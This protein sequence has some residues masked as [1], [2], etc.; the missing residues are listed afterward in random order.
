MARSK[1]WRI[2]GSLAIG[3]FVAYLD[4]TNLSVA[5]PSVAKDLGFGGE[6]FAIVGSGALTIFLVGY[7]LANV[8]GGVLTARRDPKATVI[9]CFALWSIATLVAALTHSLTVLLACRFIL[10]VAE[11]VYWPQQSRFV[12]AWFDREERTR[13]NAVVQYSGQY[14]ALAVGF[15]VLMPIYRAWG[16][17]S[18]FL[19]TGA[20]GLIIIVPLYLLALP[21]EADAPYVRSP[22]QAAA[23][24]LTLA[25]LGGPAFL[26]LVFSYLTQAMLF[27]G[28]TL[29]IPL[30]VASLGYADTAQSV[31]ASLPY[32]TALLM[33]VP[34]SHLSDRIGRR[35]E[36]AAFGLLVPGAVIMLLPLLHSGDAKL[37]VIILTLG[38]YASSYSPNIWSIV[39]SSVEPAV[40]GAAAGAINGVGAFGGVAAGFMVGLMV[41][42]TGSYVAAFAVLGVLVIL[43]GLSL[44]AFARIRRGGAERD[45]SGR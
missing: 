13:A 39:Q 17:R 6:R 8:L 44:L 23:R 28:I 2:G 30:A 26:L 9:A 16:W 3:L 33:A 31:A 20:L 38:L 35:T 14:L 29:W 5:I 15:M 24:P 37:A 7:G 18:L 34:V 45:A 4:R 11:G 25:S 42:S 19:I 40:V 12:N 36:V 22:T 32:L 10:G 21:R 43:G 27:W 1:W 41:R